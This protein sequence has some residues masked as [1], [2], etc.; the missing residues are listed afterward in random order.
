VSDKG[1]SI[2]RRDISETD[3]MDVTAH[4]RMVKY[5]CSQM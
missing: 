5:V 3:P 1:I 4:L 2:R